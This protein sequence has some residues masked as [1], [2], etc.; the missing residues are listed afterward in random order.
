[1]KGMFVRGVEGGMVGYVWA[2][3]LGSCFEK[4]GLRFWRWRWGR[5]RRKF[6]ARG[7]AEECGG[8]EA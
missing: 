3:C 2:K 4:I 8:G 6:G 5:C 7:K 1:M